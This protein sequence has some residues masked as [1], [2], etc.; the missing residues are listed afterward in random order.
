MLISDRSSDLCSFDLVP[1]PHLP[2]HRLRPARLS[3]GGPAD[4]RRSGCAKRGALWLR[5]SLILAEHGRQIVGGHFHHP[6]E[7]KPVPAG[8]RDDILQVAQAP[9]GVALPEIGVERLVSGRSRHVRA[10]VGAVTIKPAA[11]AKPPFPPRQPS[12]RPPTGRA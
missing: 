3:P 7:R 8:K 5:L 9:F 12:L 4:D 2:A 1:L 6:V 10:P 11:G